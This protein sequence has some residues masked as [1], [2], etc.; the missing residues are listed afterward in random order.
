M[1][2]ASDVSCAALTFLK[3]HPAHRK[4]RLKAFPPLR[5]SLRAAN[6]SPL[7]VS[8]FV[9]LRTILGDVSRSVDAIVIP[10]LGL[11]QLLLDNATMV[12]F[13]AILVLR[14]E[15]RRASTEGCDGST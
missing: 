4:C 10:S 13:G 7:Q 12:N 15:A 9:T 8:E 14:K 5:L 6:E 3:P 1:D 11:D 2:T